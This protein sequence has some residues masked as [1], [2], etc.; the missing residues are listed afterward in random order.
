MSSLLLP[1]DPG[2]LHL[3]MTGCANCVWLAYV[4][5]LASHSHSRHV[6][7][8]EIR[9]LIEQDVTEAG[10]KEFLLNELKLKIPKTFQ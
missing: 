7:F 1:F 9:R 10:V 4:E 6:D 8:E 3:G 2:N 5:R